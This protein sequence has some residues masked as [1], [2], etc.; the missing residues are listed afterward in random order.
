MHVYK[1]LTKDTKI[2]IWYARHTFCLYKLHV[3]GK[4]NMKLKSIETV[5]GILITPYLIYKLQSQVNLKVLK[6]TLSTQ[7]AYLWNGS[8]LYRGEEMESSEDTMYI[9]YLWTIMIIL[10]AR[11]NITIQKM[12][13]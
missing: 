13:V 9:L 1:I 6:W 11:R 5:I 10:K 4:L 3:E 12:A 2:I 7:P 8:L